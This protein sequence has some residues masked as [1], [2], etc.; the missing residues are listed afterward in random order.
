MLYKTFQK[1]NLSSRRKSVNQKTP[2]CRA[3]F[4]E[5][6]GSIVLRMMKYIKLTVKEKDDMPEKGLKIS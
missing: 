3:K 5:N 6:L 4:A 2:K 1:R